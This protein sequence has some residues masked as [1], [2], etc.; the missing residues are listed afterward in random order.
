MFVKTLSELKT[1]ITKDALAELYY[2]S[3][4]S[5]AE[6]A[7]ILNCQKPRISELFKFYKIPIDRRYR[8]LFKLDENYF[9]TWSHNMAYLL[10]FFI[11][12]GNIRGNTIRIELQEKD[13]EVLHFMKKELHA[14][15]EVKFRARYDKRTGKT[16]KSC[17]FY[18]SSKIMR[19]Q[20]EAF[21]VTSAKSGKEICPDIPTEYIPDFVRGIIDGD[22]SIIEKHIVVNRRPYKSFRVEIASSCKQFLLDMQEKYLFKTGTIR[23]NKNCYAWSVENRPQIKQLLNFIYNDNFKLERKYI[24][25]LNIIND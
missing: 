7:K 11:C 15:Q 2:T 14:E 12:D 6:I 9:S 20:L 8:R 16:Y 10:G 21:G 4:V 22:G 1:S 3:G 24:K 13:Q 25:Y 5:Q 23:K 19:Q 17:L 18:I